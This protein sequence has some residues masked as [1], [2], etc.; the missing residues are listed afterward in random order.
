MSTQISRPFQIALVVAVV[1]GALYLFVFKSSGN[2]GNS[3]TGP[4]ASSQP[5]LPPGVAGLNRAIAKAHQAVSISNAQSSGAV[6]ANVT[7]TSTPTAGPNAA[8]AAAAKPA[9]ATAQPAAA[10]KPGAAAAKPA[11][12]AAARPVTPAKPAAPVRTAQSPAQQLAQ[13]KSALNAHHV[14]AMLF[15]NPTAINDKT[16]QHELSTV[17]EHGNLVYKLAVPLSQIGS[18]SGLVNQVQINYSP[19]LVIINRNYQAYVLPGFASSYEIAGR[20]S[21]AIT[22]Q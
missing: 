2:S 19:T 14:V 11:A 16:V 3:N 8:P 15:F 4:V 13:V 12:A 22:A 21:D 9:A 10:A 18:W 1:A 17:P 5:A 20:I 6:N 7:A